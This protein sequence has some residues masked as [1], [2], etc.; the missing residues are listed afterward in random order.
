MVGRTKKETFQ[1]LKDR[2]QKCIDNWSNR[3]LSQGVKEVFVKAILQAVPI[4]TINCFLLP[5]SV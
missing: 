5:K 4:Y 1:N 3:F 2:I